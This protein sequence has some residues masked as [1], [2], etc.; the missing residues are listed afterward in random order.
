MLCYKIYELQ[1]QL[2]YNYICYLR[3]IIYLRILIDIKNIKLI[4]WNL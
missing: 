1:H 4:K 2:L 3:A